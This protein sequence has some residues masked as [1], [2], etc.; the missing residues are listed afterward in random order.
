MEPFSLFQLSDTAEYLYGQTLSFTDRKE[1][2]DF[3]KLQGK[4]T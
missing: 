2:E 4:K 1:A 3:F